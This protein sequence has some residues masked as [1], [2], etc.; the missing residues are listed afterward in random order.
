MN[1]FSSYLDKLKL[2][3]SVKAEQNCSNKLNLVH[4]SDL[5]LRKL[6]GNKLSSL[7]LEKNE[8]A[9]LAAEL[10][11]A[12][13][14]ILNSLK[15]NESENYGLICLFNENRFDLI[16]KELELKLFRTEFN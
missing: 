1:E 6:I 12:K 16:E 13:M 7:D 14:N 3:M 2:E 9:K 8:K 15:L 4:E 11:K 10:N 5:I